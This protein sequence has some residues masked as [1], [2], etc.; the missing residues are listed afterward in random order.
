[1]PAWWSFFDNQV[2]QLDCQPPENVAKGGLFILETPAQP[3]EDALGDGAHRRSIKPSE[4][5]AY[6]KK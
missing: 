5:P 4:A 2:A 3:A 6:T 1:M